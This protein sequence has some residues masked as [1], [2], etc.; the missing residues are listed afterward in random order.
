MESI[1]NTNESQYLL[2]CRAQREQTLTT[3]PILT[4]ISPH[5]CQRVKTLSPESLLS[6][7]LPPVSTEIEKAEIRGKRSKKYSSWY[8][9]VVARPPFNQPIASFCYSPSPLTLPAHLLSQPAYPAD[10]RDRFWSLW[11]YVREIDIVG[12]HNLYISRGSYSQ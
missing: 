6:S 9:L 1:T 4:S 11:S 7:P 5:P 2:T 3:C 8:S 12:C 10:E